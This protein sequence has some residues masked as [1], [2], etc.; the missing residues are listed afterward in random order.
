MMEFAP[1]AKIKSELSAY[2][3]KRERFNESELRFVVSPY[4]IFP[5]GE[6]IGLQGG[7]VMGMTINAYSVVAYIPS[8]EPSLRLYS[9]NYPG[10]SEFGINNI[11]TPE[12]GDWG[13]FA[14]GATKVFDEV[15]HLKRGIIGA[16]YGTLPESGLGSS[17]S[18][19]LAYLKALADVNR[20]EPGYSE[21]IALSRQLENNYLTLGGGIF[22]Q[23]VMVYGRENNLILIDL[24]SGSIESFPKHESCDSFRILVINSGVNTETYQKENIK[25]IQESRD[26][27]LLL[28]TLGGLKNVKSISEI[29]EDIFLDKGSKLPDNLRLIASRYYAEA[30]RVS[31]GLETWSRG[32]IAALGEKMNESGKSSPYLT[33]AEINELWEITRSTKGVYG[34]NICT[35]GRGASIAAF[36]NKDFSYQSA[37][38]ILNQYKKLHPEV[39]NNASTFFAKTENRLRML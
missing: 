7:P 26:T 28:G 29:P 6:C 8:K 17:S 33:R 11:R 34:C 36:V 21:Y 2:L 38:E 20:I 18:I 9:M 35:K 19:G 32:D 37:N 39:E 1:L 15:Y 23:S 5:L 16:V 22:D 12:K 10:V 13:R 24:T 31:A 14:M 25:Y 27:A 3:G 4:R 30:R